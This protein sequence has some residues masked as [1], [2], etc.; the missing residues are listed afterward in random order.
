[1]DAIESALLAL[2]AAVLIVAAVLYFGGPEASEAMLH[3]VE[4]LLGGAP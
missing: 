1:M 4:Q 3:S 2:T